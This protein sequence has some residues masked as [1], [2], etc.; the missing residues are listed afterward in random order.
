MDVFEAIE[1]RHSYRGSFTGAA[2]PRADLEKILAAGAAAPSGHNFQT[3]M[4]AAITDEAKCA[5][6]AQMLPG[7]YT[8]TAKAYIV[9]LS[10]QQ[11]TE[12]QMQFELQDF[13]AATENILLAVTALGYATVWLEGRLFVNDARGQL[14]TLLN[15]PADCTVRVLLPIGV[16]AEDAKRPPKKPLEERAVFNSF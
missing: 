10:R 11:F 4:F 6:I 3:P 8:A 7:P 5:Q 13:A 12:H 16:P 14:H 9:V 1:A 2:V 15:A